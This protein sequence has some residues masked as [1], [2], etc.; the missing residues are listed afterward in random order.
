VWKEEPT[1]G[2]TANSGEWGRIPGKPPDVRTRGLVFLKMKMMKS[3]ISV[4]TGAVLSESLRI[5]PNYR[6]ANAFFDVAVAFRK[7]AEPSSAAQSNLAKVRCH[8]FPFACRRKSRKQSLFISSWVEPNWAGPA[9]R[10]GVRF[11][12]DSVGQ[13]SGT[14]LSSAS[15]LT[16]MAT[17]RQSKQRHC[18]GFVLAVFLAS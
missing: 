7:A 8:S 9:L 14:L 11:V 2:A 3:D 12:P 15:F 13:T 16:E 18:R 6:V 1:L 5:V 10:A 17:R 4:I